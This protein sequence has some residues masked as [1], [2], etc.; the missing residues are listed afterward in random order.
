MRRTTDHIVAD[1]YAPPDFWAASDAD[2]SGG[3]GSGKYG[4]MLVPDSL[5]G[6]DVKF[7][8]QIHDWMYTEG[9]TIK[10]KN[11]A[12]RVLLNN[13]IRWVDHKTDFV[14]LRWLRHRRAVT[15]YDAVQ[16]FG[17]PAFWKG[18]H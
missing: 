7:I 11:S 9:T 10:H 15:Y 12:D 3:C 2:I 8:C 5:W 13:L 1:I 4:D 18:K 17:G 16:T 14:P 6:L